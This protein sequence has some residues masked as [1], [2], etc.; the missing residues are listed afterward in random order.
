MPSSRM[1]RPPAC[2]LAGTNV[3][4]TSMRKSV[5][6]FPPSCA[7]SPGGVSAS[8]RCCRPQTSARAD[9]LRR[10]SPAVVGRRTG[11]PRVELEEQ[12]GVFVRVL[13]R[14]DPGFR[15]HCH[16]TAALSS[17][18]GGMPAALKMTRMFSDCGS[19]VSVATLYERVSFSWSVFS[20]ACSGAGRFRDRAPLRCW[21]RRVRHDGMKRDI[22]LDVLSASTARSA[23]RPPGC[24]GRHSRESVRGFHEVHEYPV[25]ARN[26]RAGRDVEA[27]RQIRAG[28]RARHASC[29]VSPSRWRLAAC[30]R[31]WSTR[32]QP[33]APRP[34]CS[35]EERGRGASSQSR[36]RTR[37]AACCSI[38]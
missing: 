9:R 10:R 36:H 30:C 8:G 22:V 21:C 28:C 38:C 16:D 26:R 20:S 6:S 11:R 23:A 14:Q 37:I 17:S 5:I 31:T 27:I 7:A 18:T 34:R 19:S 2:I 4:S 29:P 13:D 33:R 35:R 1:S 3:L 12:R 24:R 25:V 32:Q 15:V